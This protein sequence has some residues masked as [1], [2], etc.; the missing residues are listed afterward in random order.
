MCKVGHGKLQKRMREP[1]EQR[2]S[3]CKSTS[4]EQNKQQQA[5]EE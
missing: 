2:A 1:E 5:P 4:S 3:N